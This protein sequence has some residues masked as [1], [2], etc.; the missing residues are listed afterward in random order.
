MKV[1]RDN[2]IDTTSTK[3]EVNHLVISYVEKNYQ[4]LI[5]DEATFKKMFNRYLHII[6]AHSVFV[7]IVKCNRFEI[8]LELSGKPVTDNKPKSNHYFTNPNYKENKRTEFK[9]NTAKI[10]RKMQRLAKL[11]ELKL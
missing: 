10:V 8:I 3:G 6:I 4:D 1:S 5:D 2:I 7:Y 11:K 9:Y